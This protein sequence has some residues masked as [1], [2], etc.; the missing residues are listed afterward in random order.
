[1]GCCEHQFHYRTPR[2]AWLQR[3]DGGSGLSEQ[4]RSF[5]SYSHHG[6]GTWVSPTLP[7]A[8]LE[9]SWAS[10]IDTIELWA[11]VRCRIYVQT[12]SFV[13]YN[14][15]VLHSVPP[16]VRWPNGTRQ[17][18]TRTVHLHLCKQV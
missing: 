14:Y 17:S 1:M 15:L 9:T 6:H 5:H 13:G 16:T 11:T 10:K 2:F 18:G 4:T 3:D 7:P 8:C 12:L